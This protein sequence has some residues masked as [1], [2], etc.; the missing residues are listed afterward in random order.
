MRHHNHI[1]GFKGIHLIGMT[2]SSEF[3]S[4]II[5]VGHGGLPTDVV[6]EKDLRI[7]YLDPKTTKCQAN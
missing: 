4:F 5:V 2:Y 1:N 3:Q 7:V 6:L